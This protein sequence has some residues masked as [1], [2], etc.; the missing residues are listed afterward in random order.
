MQYSLRYP[1]SGS[2]S[3][4][5][6]PKMSMSGMYHWNRKIEK[7][8]EISQGK[9][10]DFSFNKTSVNKE[11]HR[12]LVVMRRNLSILVIHVPMIAQNYID[13]QKERA[14]KDR[15]VYTRT[16]PLKKEKKR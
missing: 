6:L 10:V 16:S 14:T 8:V 2:A 5:A 15:R 11:L 12:I 9:N 7:F 13:P 4:T 3:G 1:H